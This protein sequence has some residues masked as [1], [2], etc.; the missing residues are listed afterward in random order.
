MITCDMAILSSPRSDT[1]DSQRQALV[2]NPA[3]LITESFM[4]SA[5]KAAEPIS[6]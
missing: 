2:L 6:D 3:N 5:R 4:S 1:V